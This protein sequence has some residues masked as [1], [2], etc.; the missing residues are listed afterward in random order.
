[1]KLLQLEAQGHIHE[2]QIQPGTR[3]ATT[4]HISQLGNS[5]EAL[6]KYHS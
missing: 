5:N 3:L 6:M 2:Y 1:M 4:F